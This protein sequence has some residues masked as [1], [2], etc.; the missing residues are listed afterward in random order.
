[1]KAELQKYECE[2]PPRRITGCPE[3]EEREMIPDQAGQWVRV[4]DVL[5]VMSEIIEQMPTGLDYAESGRYLWPK[6]WK[7]LRA[8]IDG[9][10]DPVDSDHLF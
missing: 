2:Y 5:R 9:N 4:D 10:G 3:F 7:M 6:R 1:M 8:V